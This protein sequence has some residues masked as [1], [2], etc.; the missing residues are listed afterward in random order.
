MVPA[1][2]DPAG[3]RTPAG[4]PAH[5]HRRP[6]TRGAGRGRYRVVAALLPCRRTVGP[7]LIVYLRLYHP[8]T[9]GFTGRVDPYSTCPYPCFY[10]DDGG[11]VLIVLP[12]DR[13]ATGPETG[14]G[15]PARARGKA[16]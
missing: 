8:M 15:Q 16:R 7:T 1:G 10:P 11:N 3:F 6:V 12:V 13:P 14:P 4:R 5:T 2:L 9:C